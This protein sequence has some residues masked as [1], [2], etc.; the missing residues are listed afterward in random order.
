[1]SF[2]C[3]KVLLL[4]SSSARAARMLCFKHRYVQIY[5]RVMVKS[6]KREG[7]TRVHNFMLCYVFLFYLMPIAVWLKLKSRR[8]LKHFA[9]A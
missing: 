7:N 9:F 4:N 5:L 2:S 3:G 6:I 1:M 8:G